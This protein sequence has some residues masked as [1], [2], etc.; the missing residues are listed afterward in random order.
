MREREARFCEEYLI[1]LDARAAALRAGYPPGAAESAG[2]WLRPGGAGYRARLHAGVRARMA[3]RSRRTGITAD[4]VLR[5]Y[6]RIAFASLGDILD[7]GDGL[8]LRGDLSADDLAA[9]AS[10]R[11]KG[12]S[13]VDCDVKMYDKMKALEVLAR[14]LGMDGEAGVGAAEMPR[15]VVREDGSAEIGG[16]GTE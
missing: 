2:E 11:Y 6:A 12:G 9:V 10:I 16:N 4:R 14:H 5:E 8:R 7:F 15:I 3:E 13:T 1:D